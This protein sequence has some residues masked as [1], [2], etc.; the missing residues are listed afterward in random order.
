MKKIKLEKEIE[1]FYTKTVTRF[2]NGAKIDSPKKLIG[3]EVI[4]MV[5]KENEN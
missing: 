2:G 4:V 5:L 3:K 1:G